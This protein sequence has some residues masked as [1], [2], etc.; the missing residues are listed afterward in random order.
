M[1]KVQ[2]SLSEIHALLEWE[3]TQFRAFM[4][5]SSDILLWRKDQ[6]LFLPIQEGG[7][8]GEPIS[9]PFSIGETLL[10]SGTSLVI[11]V[12]GV[13]TERFGDI[14]PEG[15]T[16]EGV[17]HW[18]RQSGQS[19]FTS[20]WSVSSVQGKNQSLLMDPIGHQLDFLTRF[21]LENGISPQDCPFGAWMWVVTFMRITHLP[22]PSAYSN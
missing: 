13:D 2:F 3:K 12:T 7:T 21:S 4:E 1:K 20:L 14:D 16:R 18:L 11:E 6:E 19:H 10:V 5:W 8:I 22:S 17:S 15:A 9:P